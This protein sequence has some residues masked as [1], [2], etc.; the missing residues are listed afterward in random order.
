MARVTNLGRHFIDWYISEIEDVRKRVPQRV[1]E[2][3][4]VDFNDPLQSI[5]HMYNE[6]TDSSK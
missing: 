5:V 3:I 1:F 4:K 6:E 2:V